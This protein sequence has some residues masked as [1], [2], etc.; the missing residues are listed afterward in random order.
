PPRGVFISSNGG[1]NFTRVLTGEATDLL[2][3]PNHFNRQYAALGEI[4]GSPTN[5]VYR[6]TNSW[7]SSQLITGPGTS[8]VS[9]T[10][11][12]RIALAISPVI[13]GTVYVGV[14]YDADT[15]GLVGIWRTDNAWDPTPTWTQLTDVSPGPFL[16]YSFALSVDPTDYTVLYF[17]ELTVRKYSSG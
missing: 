1:T 11:M 7:G 4:F 5:G 12:G 8:M 9:P 13:T 15:G 17:A 16:W 10:N 2:T 3:D 14:S 6:T